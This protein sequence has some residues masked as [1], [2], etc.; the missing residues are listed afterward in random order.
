MKKF[1][2]LELSPAGSDVQD[3][4]IKPTKTYLQGEDTSDQAISSVKTRILLSILFYLDGEAS[5]VE[6]SKVISDHE[7]SSVNIVLFED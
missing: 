7:I 5:K 6:A 3:Q 4:R 2:T 1:R